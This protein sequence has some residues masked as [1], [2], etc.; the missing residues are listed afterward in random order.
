MDYFD[1]ESDD[2]HLPFTGPSTWEPE[3]NLV[4]PLIQALIIKDRRA[5]NAFSPAQESRH[6]ISAMQRRE[7]RDLS[8]NEDVVVKPADK[9]G[10][11]TELWNILMK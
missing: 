11:I 9:G 8:S 4:S 7:L 2:N 3:L 6:N 5:F 1:F 10:Q